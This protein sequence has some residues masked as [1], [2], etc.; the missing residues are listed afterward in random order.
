MKKYILIAAVLGLAFNSSAQG[1]YTMRFVNGLYQADEYV[2]RQNKGIEFKETES[3]TGTPY[4]DPNYILGNVYKNDEL[5]ATGVALRYNAMADEIEIKESLSTDDAQAKV[6]TKTPDVFVKIVNDIYI[7]APYKGGIEEGGYFIVLFEGD[8]IGLLKKP[9]KKFTPE[10]KASTSITRDLPASFR[11][12][13]VYYIVDKKGKYYELPSSRNKKLKV[14][15]TN[16]DVIKRY[17][18]E[19]GLDLNNEKDLLRVIK[20]YDTF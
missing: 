12:K 5:W 4:N 6:L 14:F 1:I 3:Y 9:K 2:K 16:K 10:K 18:A 8:K 11:D 7:F 19:K 13:P 20:H 17:V 15:G